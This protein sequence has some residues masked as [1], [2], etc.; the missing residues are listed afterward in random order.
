MGAEYTK[1]QKRA[2]DKHMEKMAR[3]QVIV[4]KERAEIYK[5]AAKK[6]GKSMSKYLSDLADEAIAQN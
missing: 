5:D 6:A 1:A 2:Y 3:I 4:P